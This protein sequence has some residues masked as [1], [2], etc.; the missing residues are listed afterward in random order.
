MWTNE[1]SFP[2]VNK[3]KIENSKSYET[4]NREKQTVPGR[5]QLRLLNTS[6]LSHI[7]L[8]FE[9]QK[10]VPLITCTHSVQTK[11][12]LFLKSRIFYWNLNFRS[13][14]LIWYKEILLAKMGLKIL[15]FGCGIFAYLSIGNILFL[16]GIRIYFCY[17]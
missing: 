11:Q 2:H 16:K 6:S 14:R 3:V 8:Y 5:K 15:V 17:F 7:L 9:T 12:I 4:G 1:S 10:N 13:I